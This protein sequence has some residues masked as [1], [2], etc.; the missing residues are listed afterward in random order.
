[1]YYSYRTGSATLLKLRKAF[2]RFRVTCH[3][4]T[5][6]RPAPLWSDQ[7]PRS[8]EIRSPL[9]PPCSS[10]ERL[11]RVTTPR[12]GGGH[13]S[14]PVVTGVVPTTLPP[15]LATPSSGALAL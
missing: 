7:R 6:H 14:S 4:T 3:D 15:V 8:Q 10:C 5:A 13:A 11:F 1:M 2:R 9:G 12:S